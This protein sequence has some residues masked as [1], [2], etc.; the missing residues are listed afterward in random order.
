V[1]ESALTDLKTAHGAKDIAGIDAALEKLNTAWQAASQD[2]YNA[3]G[4]DAN[5]QGGA[6]AGPNANASG[7]SEVTDVDFEEVKDDKK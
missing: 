7:D 4:G 2:M 1:I 5:A 6:N 3:Q